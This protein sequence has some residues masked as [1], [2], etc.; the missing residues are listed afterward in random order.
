MSDKEKIIDI[1]KELLLKN[2]FYSTQDKRLFKIFDKQLTQQRFTNVSLLSTNE[3]ILKLSAVN[4]TIKDLRD[5]IT[6][7]LNI[8]K[9]SNIYSNRS[10]FELV[11]FSNLSSQKINSSLSSQKILPLCNK[12][13]DVSHET[14][15]ISYDFMILH[16]V[17]NLII[18]L[19]DANYKKNLNLL[20]KEICHNLIT[21][22]YLPEEKNKPNTYLCWIDMLLNLTIS[23]DLS[24]DNYMA[25]CNKI[26]SLTCF[27]SDI[28]WKISSATSYLLQISY[29]CDATCLRNFRRNILNKASSENL[30]YGNDK[31]KISNLL[32]QI[33]SKDAII[34]EDYYCLF[35]NLLDYGQNNSEDKLYCLKIFHYL[36]YRHTI[37]NIF[38]YRH[39]RE[40]LLNT[41]FKIIDNNNDTKTTESSFLLLCKLLTDKESFEPHLSDIFNKALL[42]LK[43]ISNNYT[44]TTPQKFYKYCNI[45]DYLAKR[46]NFKTNIGLPEIL[47][48]SCHQAKLIKKHLKT[49]TFKY[50]V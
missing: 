30:I 7:F 40:S 8:K 1:E 2:L 13:S 22:I 24:I 38:S 11:K 9:I 17:C 15:H 14:T 21:K 39:I 34:K 23:G 26:V 35:A 41:L 50:S 12:L 5:I 18:K 10:L 19:S 37:K 16:I 4:T 42:I 32:I 45:L 48:N 25:I 46:N 29:F 43:K 3:N 31:Q 47:A 28:L 27:N 36:F 6:K 20:K 44:A 49:I 33:L